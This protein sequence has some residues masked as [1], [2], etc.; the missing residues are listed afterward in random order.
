M[1]MI[2]RAKAQIKKDE[3]LRLRIYKCSQGK[4]TIGYGFN[5]SDN[6]I[7]THVAEMLFND[8]FNKNLIPAMQFAGDV[9]NVLSEVRQAVILNMCYQLGP[10]KLFGFKRMRAAL[11]ELDYDACADEMLDSLWA[12]QTPKRATRLAAEMR[13]GFEAKG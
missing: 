9:W 8:Q 3:G 1:S 7:S 11:L 12:T 10:E 13:L 4:L 5:L 6:P 2:T